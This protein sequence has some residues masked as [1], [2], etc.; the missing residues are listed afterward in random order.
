[1][2]CYRNKTRSAIES[3]MQDVKNVAPHYET[4]AGK[5]KWN[6]RVRSAERRERD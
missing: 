4:R 2:D 3:I 1:M 6:E 5:R